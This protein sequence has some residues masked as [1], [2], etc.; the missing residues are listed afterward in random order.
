M[1]AEYF[2]CIPRGIDIK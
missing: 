2:Y 1:Y